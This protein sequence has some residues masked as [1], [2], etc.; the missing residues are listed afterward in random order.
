ME[1]KPAVVEKN[2]PAVLCK[3]AERAHNSGK[4]VWHEDSICVSLDSPSVP[5]P[6]P[7]GND[8]MPELPEDWCVQGSVPFASKP[9]VQVS[10]N[11]TGD[12][13]A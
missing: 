11:D 1:T 10:I 5:S 8:L 9:A 7:V 4:T 2:A 3:I 13:A 6:M 12:C